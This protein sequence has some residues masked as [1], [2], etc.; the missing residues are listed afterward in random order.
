MLSENQIRQFRDTGYTIA[1]GVLDAAG[2]ER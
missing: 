2:F 1:R